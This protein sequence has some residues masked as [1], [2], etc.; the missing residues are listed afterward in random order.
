MGD[1]EENPTAGRLVAP[2]LSV[3]SGIK[4]ECVVSGRYVY[5]AEFEESEQGGYTVM[6]PQL[7]D[8]FTQGKDLVDAVDMAAEVLE[9][10]IGSYL[11]E[12]E[13]LP[14][15]IF[16]GHS[17]GML[18]IGISVLVTPE[19]IERMKCV[20]VAEAASMLKLSR[21]RISHMMDSG[22]LQAVPFGNERLVTLASIN[23]RIQEPRRA[24]RPRKK[25][26]SV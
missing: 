10:I 13:A 22:I 26:V 18:R 19:M 2:V 21:G 23:K 12:G 25:A 1:L 7:P 14:T 8:A 17:E 16:N 5:E 20:T 3:G 11:D 15:P 6:F 24:G 9:L 4:K